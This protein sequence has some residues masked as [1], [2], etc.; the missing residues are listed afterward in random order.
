MC[1]AA[2]RAW[3]FSVIPLRGFVRAR[4]DLR[5]KRFS[6]LRF[7]TIV[8]SFLFGVSLYSSRPTL[9]E[10][11]PDSGLA[12]A[13]CVAYYSFLS[14][15]LNLP[16]SIGLLRNH[17]RNNSHIRKPYRVGLVCIPF[18]PP[19]CAYTS[20]HSMQQPSIR[21]TP[22]QGHSYSV[23]SRSIFSL[24]FLMYSIC[25]WF[26]LLPLLKGCGG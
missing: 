13:P 21:S 4:P 9:I 8:T 2:Q 16:S 17:C 1:S 5:L 23:L 19:Y 20:P 22:Q 25:F 6:C 14:S 24:C 10:G 3:P 12:V 7:I 18:L 26:I 15:L 11:R